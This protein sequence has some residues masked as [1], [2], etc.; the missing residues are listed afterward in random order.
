M[1]GTTFRCKDEILK[2]LEKI[3]NLSKIPVSQVIHF[4]LS[5]HPALEGDGI[6][7]FEKLKYD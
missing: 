7:S 1:L 2:K 3:S 4:L 6:G 5:T